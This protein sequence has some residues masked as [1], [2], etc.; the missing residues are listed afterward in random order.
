MHYLTC[1]DVRVVLVE[2]WDCGNAADGAGTEGEGVQSLMIIVAVS[3]TL[4]CV[5]G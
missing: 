2:A 3:V 4:T 5:G 1:Q